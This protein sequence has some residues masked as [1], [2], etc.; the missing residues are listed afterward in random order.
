MAMIYCPKCGAEQSPDSRFCEQCGSI[1]PETVR[2]RSWSLREDP[3]EQRPGFLKTLF[4]FS[5]TEFLTTRIIKVLYPLGLV[6]GAL[7]VI[8]LFFG[9]FRIVESTLEKILYLIIAPIICFI[10]FFIYA[11]SLRLSWEFVI[12]LFRVVEHT[13]GI[14]RHSNQIAADIQILSTGLRS[15]QIETQEINPQENLKKEG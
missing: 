5:F 12:A 6:I 10:I 11:I 4:D 1:I 3:R 9:F 2:Q 8:I 14:E 15:N 7:L 13:G